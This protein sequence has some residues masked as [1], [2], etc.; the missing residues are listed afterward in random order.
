MKKNRL[1]NYYENANILKPNTQRNLWRNFRSYNQK[2]LIL[3]SK[4][5]L[6]FKQK[7]P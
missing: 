6:T 1:W 5:N 2:L 3:K 4:E 7:E